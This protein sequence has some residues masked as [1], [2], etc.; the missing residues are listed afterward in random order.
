MPSPKTPHYFVDAVHGNYFSGWACSDYRALSLQLLGDYT[1]EEHI[2]R[3]IAAGGEKFLP[4]MFA[5][6]GANGRWAEI[7]YTHPYNASP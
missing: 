7:S 6:T 2:A 1:F 3:V 4:T 5:M